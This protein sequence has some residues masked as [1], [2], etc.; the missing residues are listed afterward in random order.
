MPLT[1]GPAMFGE[2]ALW[3][4]TPGCAVNG[5]GGAASRPGNCPGNDG[6]GPVA[7][8]P[9]TVPVALVP[10][11]SAILPCATL[12]CATLPCVTL[13]GVVFPGEAGCAVVVP[14]ETGAV[15]GTGPREAAGLTCP[16]AM[17]V[18]VPTLGCASSGLITWL[19]GPEID[20]ADAVTG[21]DEMGVAGD[22]GAVE[23]AG[24]V[25]AGARPV[26]P[27]CGSAVEF[28]GNGAGTEPETR[29]RLP[30]AGRSIGDPPAL[31]VTC[32]GCSG[33]V[34]FAGVPARPGGMKDPPGLKPSVRGATCVCAG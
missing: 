15:G 33:A 6:K 8:W 10:P 29:G 22:A 16:L 34:L 21:P 7:D 27:V 3:V 13:P 9:A 32:A 28:P 20:T 23:V 1:V 31:T 18:S 2:A 12:P 26:F 4:V 5:P 24:A 14:V 30:A 11:P 25:G 17:T 19:E